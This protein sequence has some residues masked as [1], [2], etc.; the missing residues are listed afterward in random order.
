M[1]FETYQKLIG[2]IEEKG[3]LYVPLL[4]PDKN[5]VE[6][7]GEVAAKAEEAGADALLV[8]GSIIV[9]NVFEDSLKQIKKSTNLPVIIFPG[10]FNYVCK[11]AD[12]ILYL[13]L[14]SGRNPDL[15]IGEHVKSAPALNVIGL[16]PISTA[17]MLVSSGVT[18]SVEFMS[19]T[20]PIPREKPDIAIA[21]ALAAEFIG[22]KLVYL[23]T[24]SGANQS[25]PD[26]M[27]KAISSVLSIP[28]ICG[29]GIKTPDEAVSKVKS[30]AS[31][32]VTG[33]I[34]EKQKDCSNLMKEFAKAIHSVKK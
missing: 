18:T 11:Y 15:L 7:I 17:Y 8:G 5:T 29:G 12:A 33:T 14:V 6:G 23:E 30:G 1:K 13:S 20:K 16:E 24:G 27:I 4:D 9:R 2:L 28:I 25:V 32:V 19:N 26:E 21:H 10:Y 3:A 34:L 31:I 22:M